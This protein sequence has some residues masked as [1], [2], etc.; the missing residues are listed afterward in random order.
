MAIGAVEVCVSLHGLN[1]SSR[2]NPRIA[3]DGQPFF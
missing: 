1:L 3:Y 2:C